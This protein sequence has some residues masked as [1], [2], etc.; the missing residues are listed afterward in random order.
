MSPTSPA[1]RALAL[2]AT[3]LLGCAAL[4]RPPAGDAVLLATVQRLEETGAASPRWIVHCR[5]HQ[6]L[7]GDLRRRRFAFRVFSPAL[8]GLAVGQRVRI[9]A[10]AGPRGYLVDPLADFTEGQSS[11]SFAPSASS[12]E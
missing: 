8:S 6:V 11:P 3:A 10:H 9:E 7:S 4:R 1:R 5:V 12:R 2:C